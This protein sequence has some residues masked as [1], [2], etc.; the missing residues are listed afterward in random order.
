MDRHICVLLFRR[1]VRFLNEAMSYT[2]IHPQRADELPIRL[3]A[4]YYFHVNS[5]TTA[6][7]RGNANRKA[8]N[9]IFIIPSIRRFVMCSGFSVLCR[10]FIRGW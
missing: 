7:F 3:G 9:W 5:T 8:P 10:T 2:F 6:S 1:D 4:G